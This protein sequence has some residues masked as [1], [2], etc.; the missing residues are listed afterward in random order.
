MAFV[1]SPIRSRGLKK[2]NAILAK[3]HGEGSGKTTV[4]HEGMKIEGPYSP[5]GP[6]REI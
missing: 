6:N 3:K 1:C 2:A 4:P 5:K